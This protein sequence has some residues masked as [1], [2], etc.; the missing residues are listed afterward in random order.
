MKKFPILLTLL[1]PLFLLA[2]DTVKTITA[3]RIQSPPKIDGVLDDEVWKN[4]PVAT[5]FI[6]DEPDYNKPPTQR[7]EVKVL[8]DDNAIYIGAFLYDNCSDSILCE[9]GSRDEERLNAD[10]FMVGFDTYNKLIDA[11]I[12]GTTASGVQM[13][14]RFQDETYDAVWHSHVTINE[15]GWCAEFKIPYSALRFPDVKEQNWR[16]EFQRNMRRRREASRWTLIPKDAPNVVN[17]FGML[18][19]V[20]DIK[21]PLRLSIIP[22]LSGYAENAPEYNADGTHSYANSFSYN[23]GADV[24]YGMNESFTLDMTLLPDFSQVQSDN[25]VKN[26]SYREITY[27]ENRPF[28]KEGTELFNKSNLFYSRR[29]GKTPALFYDVPYLLNPGDVILKNPS[30]AKLLNA[31]KISGRN[32]NGLGIGVF[33][34]VT[35]NMYAAVKDSLGNKREMLTEPLSN[36]NIV[37]FDQQLKNSSSVYFINTNVIRSK[38][39]DDANVSGTGFELYDKKNIVKFSGDG[40][41]EERRVGKECRL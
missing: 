16:I 6:Q 31:T 25:K 15:K 5:D 12:F 17:Y 2:Q 38:K 40:R 10:N 29:I 37:V 35:D 36:Y 39:W 18:K 33:N 28:F 32:K 11:Y 27:D 4:A 1:F 23:A 41:S 7:T 8:Y 9:L 21:T 19:G 3:I 14:S 30:Q 20:T 24:K 22:Y 26:L 34:A 13:D